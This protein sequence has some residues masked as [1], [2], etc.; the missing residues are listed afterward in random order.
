[1]KQ[2]AFESKYAP[3]WETF[4]EWIDVLSASGPRARPADKAAREIGREFPAAYRQVCHHLAI[5]RT[6]RY[7]LGLQQR[8]NQLALDGHQHLYPVAHGGVYGPL[9]N[10][11]IHGFPAAVRRYW[12]YVLAS[13]LLLYL[14]R[15]RH[16]AAPSPCSPN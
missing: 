11:L 7:S 12:R 8:L 16:G 10:F 9:A 13:S 3:A 2:E 1:M 4:A 6:R 14:A 5:A 15:R